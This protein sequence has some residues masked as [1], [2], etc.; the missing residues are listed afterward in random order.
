MKNSLEKLRNQDNLLVSFWNKWLYWKKLLF[1][2]F[3]EI[4]ETYFK[5]KKLS[6]LFD[7]K[8]IFNLRFFELN[9]LFST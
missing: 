7:K 8:S 1:V 9:E 4:V 5:I 3:K 2:I 6:V